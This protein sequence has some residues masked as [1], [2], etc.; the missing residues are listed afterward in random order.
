MARGWRWK[1]WYVLWISEGNRYGDHGWNTYHQIVAEL[2]PDE[3]V[4]KGLTSYIITH[5][6]KDAE[7]DIHFTDEDP[8]ALVERLKSQEGKDI[9]ICGGADIIHQLQRAGL[10]DRYWI[11]II[12]TLLGDGIRLFG[13]LPEEQKLRLIQSRNYNGM[14]E[15]IYENREEQH[16]W[17]LP[18]ALEASLP[19][20]FLAWFFLTM[21]KET[22]RNGSV[23]IISS[24]VVN[25]TYLALAS[26]TAFMKLE[27]LMVQ[28]DFRSSFSA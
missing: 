8:A 5:R 20:F 25:L 27:M 9:W 22:P 12:P 1:Y 13:E 10:I 21:Q 26:S 14:V 23:S 19:A 6:K 16:N 2:S 4:Y 24:S 28:P 11:T 17:S 7:Q 3:W 15:L 18:D